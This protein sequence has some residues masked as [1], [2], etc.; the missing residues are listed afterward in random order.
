MVPFP[1]PENAKVGFTELSEL[2][3]AVENLFSQ[4]AD[5]TRQLNSHESIAKVKAETA[6]IAE[7]IAKLVD[8]I[9]GIRPGMPSTEEFASQAWELLCIPLHYGTGRASMMYYGT[10]DAYHQLTRLYQNK[11]AELQKRAMESL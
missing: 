10:E 5:S 11:Q 6:Q 2:G 7:K 1:A 4:T 3:L 9:D 8:D